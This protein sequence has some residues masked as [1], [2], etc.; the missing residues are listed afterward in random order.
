MRNP[1]SC[2]V[3]AAS[4]IVPIAQEEP[5][6]DVR[7]SH[8]QLPTGLAAEQRTPE[9]SSST[10]STKPVARQGVGNS[11]GHSLK[12]GL[13]ANKVKKHLKRLTTNLCSLVL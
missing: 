5:L 4:S 2:S 8:F 1:H 9:Q 12:A 13:P 11:L 10:S 7:H 6:T 3:T